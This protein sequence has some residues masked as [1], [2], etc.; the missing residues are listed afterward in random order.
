MEDLISREAAI[1]A[2][3]EWAGVD[4]FID[5]PHEYVTDAIRALPSAQP[6]D[7]DTN[8]PCTDAIDRQAAIDECLEEGG[9]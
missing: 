8:V 7:K 5:V 4:G 1:K 9:K 3:K 2:V 6:V